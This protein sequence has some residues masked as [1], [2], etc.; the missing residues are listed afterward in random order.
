LLELGKIA[1]GKS[2]LPDESSIKFKSK[3]KC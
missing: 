1:T 3:S 2:G